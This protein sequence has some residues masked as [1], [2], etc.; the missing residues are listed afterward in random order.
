MNMQRV[1]N[2]R[3]FVA[4]PRHIRRHELIQRTCWTRTLSEQSYREDR[5]YAGARS[6]VQQSYKD[7]IQEQDSKTENLRMG[8]SDDTRLLDPLVPS[9][10]EA[11]TCKPKRIS[12]N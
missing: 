1:R 5:L 8:N 4:N 2:L 7:C 12:S 9:Q 10:S 3:S 11:P 6:E